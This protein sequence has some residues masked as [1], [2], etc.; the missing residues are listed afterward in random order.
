MDKE[1]N[2]RIQEQL[3]KIFEQQDSQ[4]DSNGS[5]LGKKILEITRMDQS[6]AEMIEQIEKIMD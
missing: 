6:I 1:S 2:L 5:N 3:V 4:E